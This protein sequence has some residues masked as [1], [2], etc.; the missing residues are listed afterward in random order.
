L[1]LDYRIKDFE[2]TDID[3]P[4]L[5]LYTL[6]V[7]REALERW[8]RYNMDSSS[9]EGPTKDEVN[10]D[11]ASTGFLFGA[12]GA[13]GGLYDPP[14]VGTD[15]QSSQYM[16]I[17]L[18]GTASALFPYMIDQDPLTHGD[19]ATWVTS[20]DWTPGRYRYQVDRKFLGGNN[21]RGLKTLELSEV[22]ADQAEQW[23][24]RDG[25]MDM[26]Q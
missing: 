25:G 15:V 13:P 2:K 23:R 12:M 26:R 16:L 4:P 7:C 5:H 14:P 10:V 17:D 9:E 8:P 21:I 1:K 24:P 6:T 20:L 18:E 11:D 3:P 19:D 22:E